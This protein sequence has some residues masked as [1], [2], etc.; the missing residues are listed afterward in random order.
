[1]KK[2]KCMIVDDEPVAIRVIHQYLEKMK[3]YEVVKTGTDAMD[4]FDYLSHTTVD[5]LFLDIEMPELT[6]IQLFKTLDHPPALILITAHR[7]YAVEGFELNAVDYLMKPVSF[8]RFVKALDRFEHS[9]EE[10]APSETES[11]NQDFLF[12]TVDRKKRR[13]NPDHI[14]YVESQKDYICIYTDEEKIITRETTT[15]FERRL[16]ADSFIRIH[17]SFIVNLNKIETVGYDEISLGRHVLPVGRAYR[18]G[19]MYRL[20]IG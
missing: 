2:W 3:N 4:A 18:E 20:G 7:D 9:R 19:V 12:V 13:I 5:L 14:I 6:G 16:P 15:D 10:S 11:G 17:R 1:M 8:P